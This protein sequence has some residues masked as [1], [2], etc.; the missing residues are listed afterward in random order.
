[1]TPM[2]ATIDDITAQ[3]LDR[4]R[5]VYGAAYMRVG[6]DGKVEHVPFTD[7][8]KAREVY[9]PHPEG[10]MEDLASRPPPIVFGTDRGENQ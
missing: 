6:R 2:L 8:L 9:G 1:V 7:V 3:K 10:S 5:K 4:D